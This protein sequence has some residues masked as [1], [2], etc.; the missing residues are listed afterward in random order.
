MNE[1]GEE[2]M[3]EKKNEEKGE[4]DEVVDMAGGGGAQAALSDESSDSYYKTKFKFKKNSI[5]I[6]KK[7]ILKN[8]IKKDDNEQIIK[9]DPVVCKFNNTLENQG[10]IFCL[11]KNKENK[12]IEKDLEKK[13][14]RELNPSRNNYCL[15]NYS[16]SINSKKADK[17][18]RVKNNSIVY[19]KDSTPSP[20][21]TQLKVNHGE[22]QNVHKNNRVHLNAAAGG[23]DVAKAKCATVSGSK[24]GATISF[25][26]NCKNSQ[27]DKNAESGKNGR[28]TSQTSQNSQNSQNNE[29]SQTS[30]N[31][32]KKK[33]QS[34]NAN[35][36]LK[37]NEEKKKKEW[38]P[39]SIIKK[40]GFLINQMQEMH[41]GNSEEIKNLRNEY[42][43][44]KNDLNNIV[45][46]MNMSQRAVSS[47]K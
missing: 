36:F 40:H 17:D 39:L 8:K 32:K 42:S 16:D 29:N 3:V 15:A 31:S 38:C 46:L 34:G 12:T 22:N 27:N 26:E 30:Q 41:N 24:I 18:K 4:A 25:N 6:K 2:K 23:S 13:G 21:F 35:Q 20:S 43:K 28:Q 14:R 1:S 45:N 37:M 5:E 19:F 33:K 47:L 10:E 7:S 44:L 9:N 11:I